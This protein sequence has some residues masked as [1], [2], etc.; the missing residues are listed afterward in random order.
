MDSIAEAF[1]NLHRAWKEL[2][3]AIGKKLKLDKLLGWLE[4]KLND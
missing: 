2:I 4:A 1:E 3:L